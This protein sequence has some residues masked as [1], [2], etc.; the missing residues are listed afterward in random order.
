MIDNTVD[1]MALILTTLLS[2]SWKTYSVLLESNN[3]PSTFC[4]GVLNV[5]APVE[6]LY[7]TWI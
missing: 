3:L 5:C 2:L 7:D 6:T 4:Y 1:F